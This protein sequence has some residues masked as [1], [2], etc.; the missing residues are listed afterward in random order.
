MISIHESAEAKLQ[1][2]KSTDV[3]AASSGPNPGRCAFR[4][5]NHPVLCHCPLSRTTWQACMYMMS[6]NV[7]MMSLKLGRHSPTLLCREMKAVSHCL[8]VGKNPSH[9][10]WHQ[11]FSNLKALDLGGFAPPLSF[12]L[13]GF[14]L[15]Q[16]QSENT[17]TLPQWFL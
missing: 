12:H 11:D 9:L 7:H 1:C 15:S 14:P 2:R 4:H 3:G 13:P 6:P 8:R 17:T 16:P 5:Q 10:D